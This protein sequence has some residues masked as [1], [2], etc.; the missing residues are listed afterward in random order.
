MT[1]SP[2]T[3]LAEELLE[4]ARALD[5]YNQKHG[6]E[7]VSFERESFIDLPLEVE[8]QRKTVIDLAQDLKRLAQGPRD[9]LFE[10]C[11]H[12]GDLA[13]LDFI[14]HHK[15]ASF[16][17]LDNDISYAE[18]AMATNIDEV[19]VR[20]MVRVGMM[21]RI[22]IE[23]ANGRVRH[24]AASRI[25]HEE[26]GAMDACGFLLQEMFPAAA[27]MVE[28][29]Q[30]YPSSGEPNETAFNVAF[31]TSRPFY[32]ELEASPERAR[33]FGSAMRWMSRGGRFSN[34]HLIRGYDWASIDRAGGLVV[35]I[36]GGHGA[37]SIALANATKELRFLVQ[38][39]PISASQGEKLL[40]AELKERIS[41]MPHDFFAP[42]PI[43]G[44]DVYFFRYILHNWSDKYAERILKAA[45]PA[46]RHGSRIVCVDFL[47]GDHSETRWSDKQP[48]NMDMIQ[49][50]GWNSI[51][52]TSSDWARLFTTTDKRLKFLGTR[53]PPG[54]SV[55]IIEARF[56]DP[57]GAT[58]TN[59]VSG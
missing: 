24:S 43:E 23:T 42:Q 5:S 10:S 29:T 58:S 48:Y 2:L 54:C 7:P 49:A 21:N 35:D 25:L 15:L 30:K 19:F 47:P 27:K 32:L 33:R 26:P 8:N 53:T 22:F 45:V 12:F 11:N 1:A 38:D 34:D 4:N 6:F 31:N 18:L 59:G 57:A 14:Y 17:P 40:A 37:V 9:L 3:K 46:M 55:S 41:F 36:G 13:N 50:I 28:A 20:R 51:E 39:L 44:A 52:R 16:V 56:D